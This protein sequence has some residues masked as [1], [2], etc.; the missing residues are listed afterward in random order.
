MRHA[1]A[2]ANGID[3]IYVVILA[4]VNAESAQLATRPSTAS[5]R[6]AE[7]ARAIEAEATK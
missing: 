5:A 4:A 7:R 2:A 3:E 6:S 1:N